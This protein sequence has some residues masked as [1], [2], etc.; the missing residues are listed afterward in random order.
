[1]TESVIE[2]KTRKLEDYERAKASTEP[3]D[4][5][6]RL[7]DMEEVLEELHDTVSLLAEAFLGQAVIL[8][9]LLERNP[10]DGKSSGR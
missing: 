2:F 5:N 4:E 3:V 7:A 10:T 8:E 9:V 1:M 6:K